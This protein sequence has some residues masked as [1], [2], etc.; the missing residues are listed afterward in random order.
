MNRKVRTGPIFASSVKP[1]IV[2]GTLTYIVFGLA[3]DLSR[4][5]FD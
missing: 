1:T 5:K 2:T 4:F 3:N